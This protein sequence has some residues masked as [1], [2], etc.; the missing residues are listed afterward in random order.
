[1]LAVI[2]LVNY[3]DMVNINPH[4]FKSSMF[5]I[6]TA[7]ELCSQYIWGISKPGL[8]CKVCGMNVHLKCQMKVDPDCSTNKE[9]RIK[10]KTTSMV[11][12]PTS[13]ISLLSNSTEISC[14][15]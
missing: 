4:Q 5:T 10:P 14:K 8:S 7:C 13:R 6:P 15:G 3:V 2:Y 9:K 12:L 11:S 1:M